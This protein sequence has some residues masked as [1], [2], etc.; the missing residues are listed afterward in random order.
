MT[1]LDGGG[2]TPVRGAP[3]RERPPFRD[4][5]RETPTIALGSKE[6][7]A[8]GACTFAGLGV[9]ASSVAAVTKTYTHKS[10]TVQ[11]FSVNLQYG[12]PCGAPASLG[13]LP[14]NSP[15]ANH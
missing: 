6:A 13:H 14:A 3:E 7:K 9:G 10:P 5:A 12:H 8:S 2:A 11:A 1:A 15:H 4:L